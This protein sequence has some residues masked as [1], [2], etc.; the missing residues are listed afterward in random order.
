MI[1]VR[2]YFHDH[3][4]LC[5]QL[6]YWDTRINSTIKGARDYFLNNVFNIGNPQNPVEDYCVRP[7]EVILL[8]D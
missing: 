3:K 5:G 4:N 6:N 7:Y 1:T 8:G 2:V